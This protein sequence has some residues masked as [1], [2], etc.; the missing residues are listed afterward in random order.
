MSDIVERLQKW[1]KIY[2]GIEELPEAAAEIERLK[3]KISESGPEDDWE[4]RG[5]ADILRTEI[6]RLTEALKTCRELREY[7]RKEIELLRSQNARQTQT[8]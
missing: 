4:E 2:P 5:A 1:A 8:H 3:A 6:E 7:D